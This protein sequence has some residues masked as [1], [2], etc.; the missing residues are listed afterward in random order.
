[1]AKRV[2]GGVADVPPQLFFTVAC[3]LGVFG[4]MRA[5]IG[6]TW[7]FMGFRIFPKFGKFIKSVF[8]KILRILELWT[9]NQGAQTIAVI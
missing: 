9:V 5:S 1:M 8:L 7:I 2:K 4:P 3:L 6:S